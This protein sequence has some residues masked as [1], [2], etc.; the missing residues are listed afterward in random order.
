MTVRMLVSVITETGTTTPGDVL[1]VD[2]AIG[3]NWVAA[4]IAVDQTPDVVNPE[5]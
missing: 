4:G 2:D 3:A 1:V 5:S